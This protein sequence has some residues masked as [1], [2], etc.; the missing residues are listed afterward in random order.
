M[1]YKE[2]IKN[3]DK[4]QL[5]NYYSNH[6]PSECMKKFNI[7]SHHIFNRILDEFNIRRHSAS[8]NTSIQMKNMSEENKKIR[9]NKISQSNSGRCVSEETRRKI[10]EAEKGKKRNFK[11]QETYLKSCSTR[12]YKG[13]KAH[14]KGIYGVVKQSQ[15]T[16]IKRFDTMK[17]N[18]SFNKSKEEE[19]YYSYLLHLYSPED[20]VRQYYD[21]DRY[22]FHCDFYIKS[23]DLFIELNKH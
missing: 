14:N 22:P 12:W 7:P 20:I 18:N 17:K 6:L 3:I 13:Q 8:E 10:S 2:I 1:K 19:K 5:E 11:S 9:R 4:N 21:K 16:I 23:E 15:E